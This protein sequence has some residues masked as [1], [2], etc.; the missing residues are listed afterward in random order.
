MTWTTADAIVAH[1][2]KR[3]NRGELLAA[4]V[5]GAALF[6]MEIPLRRPGPREIADRFGEVLDWA[7]AL[8]AASRNGSDG[9][10]A[11]RHET[12]RNRVH[13]INELPVAAI[14][15]TE[16]DALRLIRKQAA[17]DRFRLIASETLCRFPQ[18]REWLARQP[19]V[20]VEHADRWSRVLAVLD[21]FIAHPRPGIY[22]RQLDIAGVDTKFIETHRGLLTELLDIVLPEEAVDR[23]A[24]GVSA[25]NARYGL[26]REPPLVR[27]R[28]LDPAFHIDGLSDLS[29]PAEQFARL[30]LAVRHVFVTENLTNGLAFPDCPA[31]IVVFG[32]G[33]GLQ[34]LA[35]VSWLRRAHVHYW[36][37]IDTHGFGILNLLRAALPDARSFLMDRP[38]LEAHRTLW[39]QEPS[40]H[41]YAGDISRL[42]PEERALFEDLQFDRLG[43]R[44][45]LEQER[46]G[47]GWL[48]QALRKL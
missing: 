26:R 32:L 48:E 25:F 29:V 4:R 31:S 3:W 1:V 42:R 18:L 30:G 9:G 45:R 12:V 11:L 13:G 23:G 15:S 20:A 19:L 38:T 14:V 8:A 39:V 44:V 10:F 7:R 2:L 6:P 40:E 34:R 35:D 5:T 16:A 28:L 43:D 17:A 37:D 22:L 36:G 21:W 27:C 33:Y 41:R 46:I 47:Y 24:S